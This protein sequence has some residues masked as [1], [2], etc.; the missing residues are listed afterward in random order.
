K[1]KSIMSYS[2][3]K[4]KVDRFLE[5]RT[6]AVLGVSRQSEQPANAN[7]R[8][9]KKEGYN[10]IP[11]NAK[12]TAVEGVTCYSSVAEIPA[13]VDAALVFTPPNA[14]AQAVQDCCEAGI[15]NIWIHKGIG[16]GS[17]SVEASKY[18][19]SKPEVNF[20]DGACPLMFITSG[21]VFHHGFKNV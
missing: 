8:A 10:V 4:A 6:I 12:C 2:S 9:L 17:R 14:T 21:D 18:L 1:R 3:L 13:H 11:V 7:F 16:G 19:G 20:I 15:T 5:S